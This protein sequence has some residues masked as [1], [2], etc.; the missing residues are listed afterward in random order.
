MS[1]TNHIKTQ[2]LKTDIFIIIAVNL[3]TCGQEFNN[4]FD[5]NQVK[6]TLDQI[7]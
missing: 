5:K 6:H 3:K 1:V 2:S 7:S 4:F